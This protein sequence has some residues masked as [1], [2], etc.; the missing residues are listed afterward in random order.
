MSKTYKRELMRQQR[1]L[2]IVINLIVAALIL[3]FCVNWSTDRLYFVTS[4]LTCGLKS[5]WQPSKIQIPV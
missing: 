1:L 3:Y 4:V 5:P 2:D